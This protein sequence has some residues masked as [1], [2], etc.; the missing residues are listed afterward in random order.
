MLVSVLGWQLSDPSRAVIDL[1]TSAIC[2]LFILVVASRM[3]LHRHLFQFAREHRVEIL[4]AI[5]LVFESIYNENLIRWLGSHI[6]D[7]STSSLTLGFLAF[8]QIILVGVLALRLLRHIPLLQSRSLNPGLVFIM[9]F[10]ALILV[11]T[12]LL[13]SPHATRSTLSWIDALFISTSAVCVTGLCP[14]DVSKVLTL[15]GQWILLGLIQAGGLGVMTLTYFFAYFLNG[16]MTLRS[17]IGLQ[18]MLSEDNLGQIG[19]VLALMIGFTALV[20]ISGAMLIHSS[21]SSAST[22]MKGLAFFS[23]FHSVSAFCNAG[24]STLGAGLADPRVSW[25]TG[26][27]SII[28]TLIVLGGLGFPVV[29]AL[30]DWI[31]SRV[32]HKLRLTTEP[33]TRLSVNSRIVLV[34]TALLLFLGSLFIWLT[35]F[36]FGSGPSNGNS[37]ATAIFHSVTARTAGF[38][39]TPVS[40][41]LPASAVIIML[42]MFAGGSPSST[43]GGIK[44][45]TLAVAFLSL[46]RVL[47]GRKEIEAFG[48]RFSDELANRALA[49]IL[50]AALFLVLVAV[51]LCILHPELPP[52]DLLFEAVSALGTVGLSRDIT[53]VLSGPAKLVL[54]LAMFVGRVGVLTFII[55][56]LPRPIPPA[57]RYP[58]TTIV[59]N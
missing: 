23:L 11:G 13:K 55:S 58:E 16:D 45:S 15:N 20:E 59:I 1:A 38:N 25:N 8:N 21:L 31:M 17:R 35:E 12:L 56:F 4:L 29:K 40:G 24:F 50:V 47:L 43:A 18:D 44:T 33:P 41:L 34:T 39:I 49:I 27:L 14:V 30:W 32:R 2:K 22:P 54:I 57:F 52:F 7:I 19:T 51:A 6:P 5:A 53:P 42:L 9:G 26:F 28:M 37:I 3:V 48:R 10:A 46:K 36:A